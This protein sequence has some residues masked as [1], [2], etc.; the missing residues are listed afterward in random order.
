MA[1]LTAAQ[2]QYIL[3]WGEMGTRWG[4]NRT[5]AQIHALLYL[6]P[7]ALPAEEIAETLSVARSNVSTSIRELE[8]WGIVRAV[9]VLGDR[10]EHYESMK[11]VCEMF[12]VITEQRKK[13]E[14]DPTMEMLEQGLAELDRGEEPD[15]YTRAR[16]QDMHEFFSGMSTLYE[17]VR[18]VPAGAL[19]GA[20]KMR[21]K[22]RK[23]FRGKTGR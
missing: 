16:L 15:A 22:I 6:S 19:R 23:L 11:D 2:K 14:I 1:E 21:G 10:R 4:I 7:R 17:E 9:H 3:H 13:R 20:L 12:R 18:Q 8:T 5:V